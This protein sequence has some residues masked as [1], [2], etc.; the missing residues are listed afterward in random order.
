MNHSINIKFDK[1]LMSVDFSI[2]FGNQPT[3]LIQTK[4]QHAEF[5]N[6]E[7]QKVCQL[8]LKLLT[9]F[10]KIIKKKIPF[11]YNQ[12]HNL[13][14]K[15]QIQEI[16]TSIQSQQMKT[17]IINL[18]KSLLKIEKFCSA[19]TTIQLVGLDYF[20]NTIPKIFYLLFACIVDSSTSESIII[21][22]QI[23]ENQLKLIKIQGQF[24]ITKLNDYTRRIK[25]YLLI[26]CKEIKAQQ[27]S[28]NLE[29][30]DEILQ[31]FT[32]IKMPQLHFNYSKKK[33]TQ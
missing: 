29:F 24:D 4:E 3:I 6:E 10:I 33:F 7:V 15:V 16:I 28:I 11:D 17:K 12:F 26:I 5:Q 25:S 22:G 8:Y 27:F 31:P 23:I 21:K 2:F 19:N 13:A 18:Q 32:N 30:N 14:N 20:I 9:V 1:Q